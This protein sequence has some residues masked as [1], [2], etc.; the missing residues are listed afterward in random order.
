[1]KNGGFMSISIGSDYNS[2]ISQLGTDKAKINTDRASGLES[3]LKT[4]N[5]ENASDEELMDVC[6]SFEAYLLEQVMTKTKKSLVG[7]EE[8]ENDYLKMFGDRLYEEY[9]NTIAD[10][11]EI[12]LAQ[13][14]YEAMKR[15]FGSSAVKK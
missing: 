5:L 1:M 2:I 13:Q 15:D 14:L 11:G 3:K 6:K 12:G 10:K 9:A 7:S 8:E 4:S